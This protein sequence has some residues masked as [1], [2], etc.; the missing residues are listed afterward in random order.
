MINEKEQD[1]KIIIAEE[2]HKFLKVI[3]ISDFKIIDQMGQTPSKISILSLLLT[4]E[5]H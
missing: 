2:G 4:S 3:K 5:A 1:E